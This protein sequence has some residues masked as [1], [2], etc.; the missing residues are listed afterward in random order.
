MFSIVIINVESS[1]RTAAKT[2]DAPRFTPITL[3][4]GRVNLPDAFTL[5]TGGVPFTVFGRLLL[6]FFFLFFYSNHQQRRHHTRYV[7][8]RSVLDLLNVNGRR[9]PAL[10][11]GSQRTF[12]EEFDEKTSRTRVRVS[13]AGLGVK[14][15]TPWTRD[16]RTRRALLKHDMK[17]N[18]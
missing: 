16:T 14:R 3:Q 1:R 9:C 4:V 2:F 18:R 8:Q 10:C 5:R 7:P 17:C 6:F 13:A 12:A 15:V 11:N